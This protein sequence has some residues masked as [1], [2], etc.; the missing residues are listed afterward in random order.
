MTIANGLA[1]LKASHFLT[2]IRINTISK[3]HQSLQKHLHTFR[4]WIEK[5][6]KTGIEKCLSDAREF[7]EKSLS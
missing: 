6:R 4:S 3:L 2:Y 1:V 5:Y 7:I